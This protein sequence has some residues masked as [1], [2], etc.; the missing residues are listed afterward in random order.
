MAALYAM[1]AV[2]ELGIPLTK[3]IRLILGTDEECGSSDIAYYYRKEKPAPM[4]FSPDASYPVVNVEKGGLHGHFTASFVP[5]DTLPR[6]VTI[7]AGTKLNVVPGKAVATV[8]GMEPSVIIDKA[9]KVETETGV[10]FELTGEGGI[11]TITAVGT[12]AHASMPE[13][14]NNAITGLLALLTVLPFAPCDQMEKIAKVAALFPHGDVNGTTLGI[15]LKD[16][17]SGRLTLAFSMLTVDASGL[18]GQF[19][20]RVPV[21]GNKENV[22]EVVKRKM[23]GQGLKLLSDSMRPSHYVSA[24]S[25]FVRT[26]LSAYE[27]Y[28]GHKGECL[29]MGGGTY[30]HELENGVAFGAAMPGTDNHM[31]GADEFAVID[32]LLVS[33]KIF[34]QVIVDLCS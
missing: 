11:H 34:A 30:V 23:E 16:E 27:S 7:Q 1:R 26:L 13:D 4:T 10:H 33:A 12:G 29:S 6:L 24:D 32:E 18:D 8:E 3:N 21:C 15:D 2:K 5:S 28:T 20:S 31:H 14:G 25:D 19:D 17:V 9:K 22:L